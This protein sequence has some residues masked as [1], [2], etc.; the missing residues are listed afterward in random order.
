MVT[1]VLA[2]ASTLMGSVAR[3]GEGDMALEWTAPSG[4]PTKHD[5]EARVTRL[6]AKPSA[7]PHDKM[8]A[9]S[10]VSKDDTGAFKGEVE[11]AIAAQSS[12]RRVKGESCE[13]VVDAIV[14]IL[15]IAIDPDAA[16]AAPQ[17]EPA[18]APTPPD[19]SAPAVAIASP[20]VDAPVPPSRD[21]PPSHLPPA[22]APTT[23]RG[24]HAALAISA[25]ADSGFFG[26][27][28]G[29][30]LS[31]GLHR[32]HLVL[33][34]AGAWLAPA[35]ASLDGKPNEGASA[36]TAQAGARACVPLFDA[37]IDV[38]P[39]AGAS[40]LWI[41]ASGYGS[42]APASGTGFV[43]LP[44]AGGRL[45]ARLTSRIALR[46]GIDAELPLNRPRFVIDNS[47]TVVHTPVAS[48]RLAAGAE[49][50]F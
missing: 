38:A 50:H 37:S 39:C 32:R 31:V 5:V 6:V 25:L 44:S 19:V 15:A 23:A 13:A 26:P 34:A 1:L 48:A 16:L 27:A 47:G 29:V 46:L 17:P 28:P 33:E 7:P 24:T 43:L 14:L 42:D 9:R 10:V 35:K 22:A 11:L 18:L 40:A 49:L 30:E 45:T 20:V 4:C 36:W 12:K 2:V 8:R 41:V 21:V 3:A